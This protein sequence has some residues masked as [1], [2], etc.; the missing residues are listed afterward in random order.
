LAFLEQELIPMLGRQL[1]VV[2]VAIGEG[3]FSAR[4]FPPTSRIVGL[5]INPVSLKKASELPHVNQ[6][7]VCDCLEPPLLAGSFDV[8]LANNFLHHVSDKSTTLARWSELVCHVVFNEST[9]FWALS[10]P[11]PFLLRKVGLRKW[12]HQMAETFRKMAA[13]DLQPEPVVTG[14][15][16]EHLRIVRKES[17]FSERTYF[18]ANL[19]CLAGLDVVIPEEV[20]RVLLGKCLRS[21]MVRLTTALTK[22]L[23]RFDQFQDRSRDVL[24]SYAGESKSGI[25]A[26]PPPEGSLGCPACK[27]G[28]LDAAHKCLSCGTHYK[29][30]DGMLFLLPPRLKHIAETYDPAAAAAFPGEHL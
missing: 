29:V 30:I 21:V 14:I 12:G 2:E 25:P 16:E 4:I 10:W 1:K 3:T 22:L 6:A 24:I 7:V 18:L 27:D 13:Q 23:L 9:P 19:F 15:V 11:I 28:A 26:N 20:K 17:Y 5:D 8:L